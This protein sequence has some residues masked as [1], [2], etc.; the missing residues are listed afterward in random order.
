MTTSLLSMLA[1][2]L[3][4]AP[5]SPSG[6]HEAV[7]DQDHA[8][9]RAPGASRCGGIEEL[10]SSPIQWTGVAVSATGRVF[11]NYP[12][13][14]PDLPYSVA[15]LR[16]AGEVRPYP[17]RHVNRWTEGVAGDS[18]FVCVQSVTCD[19]RGSLWVLDAG[20]PY[21]S[22]VLPGAAKL[23]QVDLA[24]DAVARIY[25]FDS[26]AAPAASYLN[27]VRVDRRAG[28]A[29]LTDSGLGAL[30]VLD[31]ATGACRRVLD[32]H[33]STRAEDI[34]VTVAG[35]RLVGGDG[36]P[37]RVHSDGI[38]LD[39]GGSYVYYQALTGRTLYRIPTAALRDAGLSEERLRERVERVA[40]PGVSDGLIF[41]REGRLYFSALEQSAIKRMN[42]GRRIEIVVQDP[43]IS[44]P[45]S[46]AL[47]PDGSV[48]FTTSRIHE[49][50]RFR[51]EPKIYRVAQP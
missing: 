11:V 18:H 15:E 31:L 9:V 44:W 48:C 38:A 6:I 14:A 40:K 25:H 35:V 23:V 8:R 30:L 28:V 42:P 16:P 34:E 36:R 22:G 20:S 41:D 24:T 51:E 45:D 46:F 50:G 43:R 13:W 39:P 3:L 12:R 33:P 27:D 47:M 17:D 1:L 49:G 4:I 29:Y 5:A 10:Y 32:G 37:M 2:F 7:K 21:L 26:S 19:D